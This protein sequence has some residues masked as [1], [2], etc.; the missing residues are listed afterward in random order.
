MVDDGFNPAVGY[1]WDKSYKSSFRGYPYGVGIQEMLISRNSN[2]YFPFS[3]VRP[4][5]PL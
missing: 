1:Q 5:L 3:E 2:H 4:R